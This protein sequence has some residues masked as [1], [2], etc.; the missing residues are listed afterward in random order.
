MQKDKPRE[1]RIDAK[2][3]AIIIFVLFLGLQFIIHISLFA[4]QPNGDQKNI[5]YDSLRDSFGDMF[6]VQEYCRSR[7]PYCFSKESTS[8]Y[9]QSSYL[10][11]SNLIIYFLG[12]FNDPSNAIGYTFNGNGYSL[13]GLMSAI[14][15]L[16]FSVFLLLLT[17]NYIIRKHDSNLA[18]LSFFVT[19][20]MLLSKPIIFAFERGNLIILAIALV[21]GFLLGYSSKNK[22][23][24]ELSFILLACAAALKVYPAF[25]GVLLLFEKRWKE[26]ARLVFYG[27]I[28]AFLPFLFFK[29]GFLCVPILLDNLKGL[30][31]T[32]EIWVF[33]RLNYHFFASQ[34]L[35]LPNWLL[36]SCYAIMPFLD[37]I[38][39]F[40][41]IISVPY[42]K[43]EWEKIAAIILPI[44]I[45]P[46]NSGIYNVLYLFPVIGLYFVHKTWK[47]LD[48]IFLTLFI[49]TLSPIQFLF[50]YHGTCFN[51]VMN[52]NTIVVNIATWLIFALFG[53]KGFINI[54]LNFESIKQKFINKTQKLRKN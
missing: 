23:I 51:A 29:G 10:P 12:Q 7:D 22:V 6:N 4:A 32:Y 9:D 39:A 37:K 30:S 16:G 11:L 18:F 48:W 8:V 54:I 2:S 3:L 53:I 26:S 47:K 13:L 17:V 41:S 49:L 1:K 14:L 24:R 46:I 36:V 27:L 15:F 31:D 44:I 35:I 20:V 21:C 28:A 45:L 50:L 42:Y 38:L 19:A 52:L 5:F 25:L 40:F 33:P 34:G 43:E